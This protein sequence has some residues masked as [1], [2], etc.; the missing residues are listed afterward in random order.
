MFSKYVK[1]EREVHGVDHNLLEIINLQLL[2]SVS[3]AVLMK[4][5]LVNVH[6]VLEAIL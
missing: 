3:I 4:V 2:K 6:V 5:L 1:Q